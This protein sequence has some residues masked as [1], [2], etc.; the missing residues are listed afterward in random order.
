MD[1][2]IGGSDKSLKAAYSL[3]YVSD[4]IVKKM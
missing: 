2:S 1:E 3:I 4:M